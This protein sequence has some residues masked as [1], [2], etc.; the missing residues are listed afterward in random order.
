M[1]F[2]TFE[3]PR[4][5]LSLLTP[6]GA[7][8][9]YL[10]RNSGE[11]TGH[12]LQTAAS[13]ELSS[14]LIYL[15][16]HLKARPVQSLSRCCTGGLPAALRLPLFRR[17]RFRSTPCSLVPRQVKNSIPLASSSDRQAYIQHSI[18]PIHSALLQI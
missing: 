17:A 3:A 18:E 13:C 2:W 1:A 12:G 15:A 8:L 6:G 4:C 14:Q 11:R 9:F 7:G 16:P 5:S 10:Q